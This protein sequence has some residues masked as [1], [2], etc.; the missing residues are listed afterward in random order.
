MPH[1]AFTGRFLNINKK[2]ESPPSSTQDVRNGVGESAQAQEAAGP[3]PTHEPTDHE[4]VEGESERE[5][6]E[7]AGQ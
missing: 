2:A 4:K 7:G 6:A 5:K 3:A 1:G